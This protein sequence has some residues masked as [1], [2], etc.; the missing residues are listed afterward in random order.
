MSGKLVGQSRKAALKH[1]G[2]QTLLVLAV[3]LI[4]GVIWNL[5]AAWSALVGGAIY[6]VPNLVFVWL[7]FAFAGA[8]QSKSV[9]MSLYLGEVVKLVLTIVML[10]IA[11]A[12]MKLD[13]L[14]LYLAFAVAL[15]AQWSIPFFFNNNSGMKNGCSR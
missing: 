4:C 13:I 12:W 2:F 1:V 3:T 6:I 11:L 7:A 10:A 8:R 15:V 5:H 9:V 14:S